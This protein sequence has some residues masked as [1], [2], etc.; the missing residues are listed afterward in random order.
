MTS[1]LLRTTSMEPPS[2]ASV[3]AALELPRIK[4]WGRLRQHMLIARQLGV[5]VKAGTPLS[6][7][8][9]GLERQMDEPVW[10]QAIGRVRESVESGRPLSEA[11]SDHPTFFGSVIC[12]LVRTGEQ[13]GELPEVLDRIA[14]LAR[15]D[16]KVRGGVVGALAYPAILFAV[17]TMAV[18]MVLVFV[19][20]RFAGMFDTLGVPL[21]PTTQL[22]LFMSEVVRSYWWALLLT[23]GGSAAG[24]YFWARGEAGRWRVDAWIIG[25]PVIGK[26][27]RSIITGRMIRLL[28]TLI[29][30]HVSVLEVLELVRDSTGHRHYRR[31]LERSADAVERGEAMSQAFDDQSLI[32]PSVYEALKSGEASGRISQSLTTLA[33]FMEEENDITIRSLTKVLEPVILVVLGGMIGLLAISMFLP[34]F[35]LTA[36]TGGEG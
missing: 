8:L 32:E 25:L 17:V 4:R 33:D 34:L 28:G 36:M 11:M 6:D 9:A 1:G 16:L 24:V 12:S 2:T 22:V 3:A 31:L 21:P 27:S 19:V 5:L 13:T 14:E 29:S 15:T 26:I 20:P 18:L 7:A 35:D 30:S 23:L 10:K